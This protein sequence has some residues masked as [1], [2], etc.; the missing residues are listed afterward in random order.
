MRILSTRGEVG[1][2]EQDVS[3][4]AAL[5]VMD[6]SMGSYECLF[7]SDGQVVYWENIR[8]SSEETL[9][10]FL[11]GTLLSGGWHV[12]EAWRHDTLVCRFEQPRSGLISCS[13]HCPMR[14]DQPCFVN[15]MSG[16]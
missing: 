15:S 16:N 4:A 8:A 1:E 12:G 14:K 3:S 9:R 7:F 10:D 6:G 5:R 13:P 2:R 11:M